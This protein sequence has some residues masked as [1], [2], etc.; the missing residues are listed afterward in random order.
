MATKRQHAEKVGW[1]NRIR[2]AT[3]LGSVWVQPADQAASMRLFIGPDGL[4]RD[5]GPDD[6]S[7]QVRHDPRGPNDT[8]FGISR[9]VS[10]DDRALRPHR[11][12]AHALADPG[13]K[14]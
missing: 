5:C 10:L 3:R 9:A 2:T 7:G 1:G 11:G 6:G 14:A 8:L 4:A 13:Q 12:A